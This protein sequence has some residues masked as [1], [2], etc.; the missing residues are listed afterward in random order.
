MLLTSLKHSKMS[1]RLCALRADASGDQ[2]PALEALQL[3]L[4]AA[5]SSTMWEALDPHP[6]EK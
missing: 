2:K 6:F 5:V 3:E 1:V 4:Q